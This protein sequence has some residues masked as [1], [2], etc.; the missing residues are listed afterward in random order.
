MITYLMW[1]ECLH[2]RYCHPPHSMTQH[3]T[4]FFGSNILQYTLIAANALEDM[5]AA[6]QLPFLKSV[7]SLSVAIISII[8][9]TKFHKQKCLRML[10]G[11]HSVLCTLLAL[12]LHSENIPCKVLEQ[13]ARYAQTLEKI[14]TCLR[15]QNELGK[16]KRF[17]K[18]SEIT[19]QL[20]V[21]EQEL[22]VTADV[23]K[24]QYN[25]GSALVELDIDTERRHQELLELIS[26]RSGSFTPT[27]SVRR[28]SLTGSSGS[29]SLLPASPKIFHG[30]DR[31][32]NDVIGTLLKDFAQVAVL[33]PGGMALHHPTIIDKYRFRH[34]ISCESATN[35]VDLLSIIGSHLGLDPAPQLAKSIV[36]YLEMSGPCLVVLDNFE[37]PWEPVESRGAV[38]EFISYWQITAGE[39]EM[40]SAVPPTLEPL[41]SS[42]ARRI[43]S[44]VA[45]EPDIG[46]ESA[47]DELLVLSGSLPLAISLMANVASFEGYKG[48]LSRWKVENTSLL[49]DG[50]D[51]RSNLEISITLSLGSP[52]ISS[53]PD[54]KSLL[55]LLS[56]LPDGITDEDI[57]ASKVPL[58]NIAHCRSS[59]VRTSLAYIDGNGRLKVLSPIRE[60][61]RKV[62]P[63]S[64][65]LYQ[66][67]RTHFHDLLALSESYQELPSGDLVPRILMHLG[68]I[69]DLILQNLA[70]DQSAWVDIA[71]SI[72]TLNSVSSK[73]LKGRS[74][75]AQ[76]LPHLIEVTGNSQLRWRYACAYLE[77]RITS[78]VEADAQLLIAEGIRYFNVAQCHEEG[79][80]FVH[81]NAMIWN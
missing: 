67:L 34:F 7:S 56:I 46:E 25:V 79:N 76:R 58:P 18:Q 73:M 5:S 38:E 75:L 30:R 32:L 64:L 11:V 50:H 21:C 33:G 77:G 3:S 63:P 29:L 20:D 45:D 49:S 37:T 22:K 43:F 52:R 78:I 61:I 24:T 39:S 65:S 41:S 16:I 17:F 60:Y 72:L 36:R 40:E 57:I 31:E 12:C 9:N 69:N 23:F 81:Q 6:T 26:N 48:A 2:L 19:T 54:A 51:K 42:A 70:D 8:D 59:L 13:I 71:H 55:S 47:L 27:S 74:P 68:N 4:K 14:Y 28:S 62:H 44:E 15:A 66:P 10:E 80:C 35:K 1:R 53:S